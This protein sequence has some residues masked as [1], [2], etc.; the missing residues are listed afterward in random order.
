[1]WREG[2]GEGDGGRENRNERT[3]MVAN[4]VMLG[5]KARTKELITAGEMKCSPERHRGCL[6]AV[7]TGLLSH[8][9]VRV[10]K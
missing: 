5:V 3:Q 4:Y 6:G 10:Q 7:T 1:M 2:E 8:G 9:G